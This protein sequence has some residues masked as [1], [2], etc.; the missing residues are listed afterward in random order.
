MNKAGSPKK[1]VE[2]FLHFR[3]LSAHFSRQEEIEPELAGTG[4]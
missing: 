3:A 4:D 1:P 2:P